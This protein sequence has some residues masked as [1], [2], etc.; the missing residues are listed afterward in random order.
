MCLFWRQTAL[1]LISG[2]ATSSHGTVKFWGPDSSSVEQSEDLGDLND[3]RF[4]RVAG[5]VPGTY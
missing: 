3:M 4:F 5:I 2:W 1:G